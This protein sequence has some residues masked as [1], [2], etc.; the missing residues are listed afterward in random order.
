MKKTAEETLHTVVW[1]SVA[2]FLEGSVNL[3]WVTEAIGTSGIRGDDL[4]TILAS[5]RG[6]GDPELHHAIFTTCLK[7]GWIDNPGEFTPPAPPT[8]PLLALIIEDHEDSGVIFASALQEAGFECEIIYAGD[9]ALAR[10]AQTTPI[11]VVL[12]LELPRVHGTEILH[13]I[14]TDVRLAKT[15]VIIATAFHDMAANLRDDADLVL[16]KPISYSQLRDLANVCRAHSRADRS[17]ERDLATPYQVTY[18][19][20]RDCIMTRIDGMLDMQVVT[21]FLAELA[22][23][24]STSGCQRILD[25]LRGSRSIL[26]VTD[27][28]FASKLASEKGILPSA[29]NAVIVAEKDRS[30]YSSLEM[31]AQLQGL[32]VKVFTDPNEARHWL[33]GVAGQPVPQIPAD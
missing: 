20:G 22:H 28:Y 23:Q 16:I 12:D 11:V 1:K 8:D 25:D 26:S 18:D 17:L 32:V 19:P 21:D 7:R 5:L 4:V 3:N 9:E 29:K 27:F 14:R 6:H 30:R 33:T 31:T 2:I 24:V 13:Q 10:L 15:H